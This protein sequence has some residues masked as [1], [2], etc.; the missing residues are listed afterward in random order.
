[1]V[2]LFNNLI[3]KRKW[4]DKSPN[5]ID[6]KFNIKKHMDTVIDLGTISDNVEKVLGNWSLFCNE[7][8]RM[9]LYITILRSAV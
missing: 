7:L 5:M 3:S 4:Q 9:W 8:P 1:M 2:L 6:L